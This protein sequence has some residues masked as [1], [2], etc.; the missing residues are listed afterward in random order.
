MAPYKRRAQAYNK[1]VF[2][3]NLWIVGRGDKVFSG[4]VS[5]RELKILPPSW[6]GLK[7]E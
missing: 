7:G 5:S 6:F 3:I 2:I 4:L 1:I